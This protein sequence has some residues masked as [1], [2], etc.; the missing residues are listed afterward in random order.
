M[1]AA[2]PAALTAREV[3]GDDESMVQED[4]REDDVVEDGGK[5]A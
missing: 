3:A 2:G 4:A 1:R 5:V